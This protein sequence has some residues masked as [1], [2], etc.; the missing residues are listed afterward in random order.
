[1]AAKL[2]TQ[3]FPLLLWK[4]C[5]LLAY[6]KSQSHTTSL[7]SWSHRSQHSTNRN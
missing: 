6:T 2:Q 5:Q 3:G 1:M 4:H 7:H